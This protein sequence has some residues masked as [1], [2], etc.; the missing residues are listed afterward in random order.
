MDFQSLAEEYRLK[1]DDEI[2][3]LVLDQN[4][5]TDEARQM[6]HAEMASRNI[7]DEEMQNYRDA[8][9]HDEQKER[10]REMRR[11]I[12]GRDRRWFG[13][14]DREYDPETKMER[15]TTTVFIMIFILPL[16][17]VGTFRI[18][19]KRSFFSSPVAI[20]QL[21]LNW[22]QVLTVWVIAAAM[23][24]VV[25]LAVKMYVYLHAR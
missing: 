17:P 2:M 14:W 13:K 10:L 4:Q 22:E 12:N 16:I 9:R 25:I 11:K 20:E 3:R 18:R 21:A 1:S 5:L 8:D 15:F 7:S 23:L 24:F 19:K 6:L